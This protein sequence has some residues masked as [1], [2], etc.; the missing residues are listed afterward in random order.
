MHVCFLV[1]RF[2]C[3]IESNGKSLRRCRRRPLENV[4]EKAGKHFRR[5]KRDEFLQRKDFLGRASAKRIR[6]FGR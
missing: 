4:E 6:W 2:I 5:L 1:Q 3:G